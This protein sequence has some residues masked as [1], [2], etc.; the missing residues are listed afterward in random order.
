[1]EER[2]LLTVEDGHWTQPYYF[3]CGGGGVW[4]VTFSVPFFLDVD[5][6]VND[7]VDGSEENTERV[8]A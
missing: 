6:T 8:F 3:D 4:M 1:M 2:E 7:T 5:L